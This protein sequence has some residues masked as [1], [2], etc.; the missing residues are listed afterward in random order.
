[1]AIFF[2]NRHDKA[3]RDALAA[4]PGGAQVVDVFGGD[5]IP[6]GYRLSQL[7][8]LVD[9]R[10]VLQTPGPFMPGT[11]VLRWECQAEDGTPLTE[12]PLLFVTIN[13]EMQDDRPVNGILE[14]E[15]EAPSPVVLE[16]EIMN[17]A[18]GYHPW[19]GT[20][21]VKEAEPDA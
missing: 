19:R 11:F 21:E 5:P 14:V 13:G 1:M 9:K 8:Y 15:I 10:L 12:A 4:L 3:S 17:D 2:H 16:I 20:V 6:S 7:P 18:D